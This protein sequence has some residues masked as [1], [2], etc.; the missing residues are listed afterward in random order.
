[1]CIRDSY[2]ITLAQLNDANRSN[3]DYSE[4]PIG[5]MVIIPV[6]GIMPNAAL[7]LNNANTSNEES[8]G[9]SVI[10]HIVV[11]GDNPTVLS[12]QYSVSLEDLARANATN[13]T[14]SNFLLGG[15]IVIPVGDC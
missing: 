11:S 10:E 2:N 7:V 15:T 3:T 8:P 6:G 14:Y 1:M 4:F 12:R 5:G 13:S 9:C